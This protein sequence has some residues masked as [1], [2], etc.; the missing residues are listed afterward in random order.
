MEGAEAGS[1]SERARSGDSKLAAQY[2]ALEKPT[3]SI[4]FGFLCE[5]F[6]LICRTKGTGEKQKLLVGPL[7]ARLKVGRQDTVGSFCYC[8]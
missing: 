5:R 7:R 3:N 2:E 8:S 1:I 4:P 6:E